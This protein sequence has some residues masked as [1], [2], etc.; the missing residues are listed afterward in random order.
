MYAV[1]LNVIKNNAL[2]GVGMNNY[3]LAH[4]LYD[5]TPERVSLQFPDSPVHNLYLLYAA[6]LGLFGV[7]GFLW[8]LVSTFRAAWHRLTLAPAEGRPVILALACGVL[9]ICVQNLTGKGTSDHVIHLSTIVMF[10]ALLTALNAP[11]RIRLG[12]TDWRRGAL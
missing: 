4:R 5:E 2:L 9:N 8:F 10:A 7:V 1:A 12:G 6:E 3:T 11:D